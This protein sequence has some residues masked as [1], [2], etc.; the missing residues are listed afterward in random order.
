MEIAATIKALKAAA[1]VYGKAK[2]IPEQKQILEGLAVISVLQ[3]D[4]FELEEK[5]RN[6]TKTAAELEAQLKLK[7]SYSL[8]KGVY[9]MKNDVEKEQPFCPVCYTK[10]DV[11]PLQKDWDGRANNQTRWHCPNKS[12]GAAFNPWNFKE[13]DPEWQPVSF[14]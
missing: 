7:D 10:G 5:V 6:V 4:K 12:C 9:W 11:I 3:Q 1:D 13:P 8:E 14:Y 2:R